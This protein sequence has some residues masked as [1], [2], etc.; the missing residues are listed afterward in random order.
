[1]ML[2]ICLFELRRHLRSPFFIL[3]A[4][5]FFG[6][7]LLFF[8]ASGGAFEGVAVSTGDRE[9][10]NSAYTIHQIFTAVSIFMMIVAAAVFGQAVYKDYNHRVYQLFFTKPL[11]KTAYLGGRFLAAWVLMVLMA[12][13]ALLGAPFA[14]ILPMVEPSLFG[15]NHLSYYLN[16]ILTVAIPNFFF[17]GALFFALATLTRQMFPVYT[18]AAILVLGNLIAAPLISDLDN[19]TMAA[20]IEPFGTN[21]AGEVARYWSVAERNTSLMPLADAFLWNRLVWLAVGAVTLAL[22]WFRFRFAHVGGG[23]RRKAKGDGDVVRPPVP[24][25]VAVTRVFGP[26]HAWQSWWTLTKLQFQE[27]ILNRFFLV[28][29]VFGVLFMITIARFTGAVMGTETY[30]VTYQ[31]LETVA[32]SFGLFFL[33]L[34]T[35]LA[36][37]LIW[38]ERDSGIDQITDALPVGDHVL[39]LSKLASILGVMALVMVVIA[40]TGLGIQLVSAPELIEPGQYL[41]TLFGF[42]LYDI[43]L[44]CVLAFLLHA[45]INHKFGGHAGMVAYYGIIL[46][47]LGAVGWEHKLYRVLETP[48]VTYS[49]MNGYGFFDERYL[50]FAVYWGGLALVMGV[51][52]YLFWVRGKETHWRKRL[53]LARA[54]MTAPVLAIAT[55]GGLVFLGMA[56]YLYY[57]FNVVNTYR[58]SGDLEKAQARFEKTYKHM[59]DWPALEMKRVRADVDIFPEARRVEGRA[60]MTMLNENDEPVNHLVVNVPDNVVLESLSSERAWSVELEDEDYLLTVYAFDAPVQPGESVVLE[61]VTALANEGVP[62]S[63]T[64]VQV[65][66]NGTFVNNFELFPGFGYDTSKEL[67][68]KRKRERYDLPEKPRMLPIDD[69]EGLRENYLSVG[70]IE[71]ETVVSTVSDQIAIAPGYLI[72]E[73]EENGRRYF[74]YEMDKPIWNFYS[75]MS[76]RYEVARDRWNGVSLEIYYDPAHAFN[77]DKMMAG[78]KDGLAYFDEHFSP[79]QHR[80]MRIIEFPRY[81]QFAQ[82]FPNTVPFAETMGFISRVD[83]DNEKDLDFPYYVTAHEVA[84]QWWAH[85]VAGANVQG[86]TLL[87]ESLSQYSALMVLKNRISDAQMKRFLRYELDAYLVGRGVETVR[88]M[89]LAL[90]ENQSYIHYRKGS[91]ALYAIQDAIGEDVFNRALANFLDKWAY[92]SEPYPT[93]MDLLAEIKAVAPVEH[94]ALIDDL[95]LEIT[96]WDFR[97]LKA[98]AEPIDGERYRVALE[99]SAGKQRSDEAGNLTD[100]AVGDWV[101]VGVFDAEDKPLYLAKHRV[102]EAA[103]TFTIEVTGKPAKA[104][105]DPLHKLIDRDPEDNVTSVSLEESE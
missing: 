100:I 43:W 39:M 71:L 2:Q 67:E 40:M 19:R 61:V 48:S 85:Q 94:H 83:P 33:I 35:F 18:G 78:M 89:P 22:T 44:Y 42:G 17:V 5:L 76:A 73:W 52:A 41:I 96:L 65:V 34:V 66:E 68:G 32:S 49:D 51:T 95:I 79:F 54:K 63:D 7:F 20:I 60:T 15:P 38:R 50:L 24:E 26:S 101:D 99:V 97:A 55:V 77:I 72:R 1:M 47:V 91:V 14:S 86:A 75:F 45:L 64:M 28:I 9:L 13:I 58:D 74:H 59:A 70:R 11:T 23:S 98:V 31:V 84:H 46:F 10:A 90:N 80:Q 30:P 12:M 25:P 105:I 3:M 93:S 87:S 81:R 36:G 27:T 104:G 29:M 62:H 16:P 92:G 82:A 53:R 6:V 88:E 57:N 102:A 103:Q 56:G 8:S 4:L 69:P 21:A 37:E